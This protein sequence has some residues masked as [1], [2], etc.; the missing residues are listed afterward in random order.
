[1]GPGRRRPRPAAHLRA[2][3]AARPRH[4]GRG[5]E[6]QG[7]PGRRAADARGGSGFRRRP[8]PRPT[9]RDPGGGP[10]Q[11]ARV[12][13]GRPAAEPAA[14]LISSGPMRALA[15][16]L[17]ASSVCLAAGAPAP[18]PKPPAASASSVYEDMAVDLLRG[19]LQVDTTNPPGNELKSALFLKEALE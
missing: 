6:E 5:A 14:F 13:E 11:E 1:Q 17:A 19:Y 12:V 7:R 2:A 10:A 4:Q 8:P 18:D 9:V 16:V 3:Q 15:A